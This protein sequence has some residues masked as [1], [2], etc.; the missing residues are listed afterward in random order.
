[1]HVLCAENNY[2][3]V[4]ASAVSLCCELNAAVINTMRSPMVCAATLLLLMIL[5]IL[6][7]IVEKVRPNDL[8][9]VQCSSCNS[10]TRNS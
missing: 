7:K 9:Y 6:R 5:Y 1:M 8:P 4:H 10:R 3:Q 2:H